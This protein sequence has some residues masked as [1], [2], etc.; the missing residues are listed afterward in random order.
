MG[1]G[2]GWWGETGY[3]KLHTTSVVVVAA[4]VVKRPVK[5]FGRMPTFSV[6]LQPV[7][8]ADLLTE[9]HVPETFYVSLDELNSRSTATFAVPKCPPT[10]RSWRSPTARVDDDAR[11]AAAEISVASTPSRMPLGAHPVSSLP[12]CPWWALAPTGQV[13]NAI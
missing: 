5:E 3:Y 10:K 9:R 4:V 1:G 6:A 8:V 2:G 11:R 13:P 12:W 7:M